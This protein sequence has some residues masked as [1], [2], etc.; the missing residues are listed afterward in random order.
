MKRQVVCLSYLLQCAAA[1]LYGDVLKLTVSLSA[2][3]TNHV[4]MLIRLPQQLN[5]AVGKAEAFWENPLYSH[6]TVIK[7]TPEIT[8]REAYRV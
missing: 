7:L 3:V 8:Q 2:E 5:L 6:W 1:Q 4:W